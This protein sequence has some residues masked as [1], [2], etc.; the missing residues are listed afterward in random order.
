MRPGSYLEVAELLPW[1]LGEEAGV[2][3]HCELPLLLVICELP[4]TSELNCRPWTS[5]IYR[6][7]R[8]CEGLFG[9]LVT[10]KIH[11]TSNV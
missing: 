7:A 5:S 9:S 8:A 6:A 4:A 3:R 2:R 1:P 11:V 10:P